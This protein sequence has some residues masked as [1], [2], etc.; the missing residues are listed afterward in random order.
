M[1]ISL[2]LIFLVFSNTVYANSKYFPEGTFSVE[3]ESDDS[4]QNW[5]SGHLRSMKE[6]PLIEYSQ[7]VVF[8]FTWL[9]TF[10]PPMAFRLE[11]NNA[12]EYVLYSKRTNGAG[13]YDP[14]Q[15]N[16]NTKKVIRESEA[17]EL[18]VKIENECNFWNLPIVE[19]Q[20]GFDGS[21][22]IFEYKKLQQ[23]HVVDRWTPENGC[24]YDV[25]KKLMKMS[26]ARIREIY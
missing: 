2:I 5:Y 6:E 15:L 21:Q 25:G 24:M 16:Y 22:W 23:Y 3:N 7:D 13:G 19:K 4:V 20:H 17:L 26:K 9:P 8:R 18:L 12:G 11:K 10:H 1:K 14:G